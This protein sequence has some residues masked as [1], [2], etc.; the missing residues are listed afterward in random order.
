MSEGRDLD[1][2]TVDSWTAEGSASG[3]AKVFRTQNIPRRKRSLGYNKRNNSA[4]RSVVED[5]RTTAVGGQRCPCDI[6]QHLLRLF[7]RRITISS[8]RAAARCSNSHWGRILK[9]G[10]ELLWEGGSFGTMA[11]Y[12]FLVTADGL[13]DVGGTEYRK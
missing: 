13:R 1:L 2:D 6:H 10:P 5:T 8:M 4:K 9:R 7:A 11:P 12:L 3:A